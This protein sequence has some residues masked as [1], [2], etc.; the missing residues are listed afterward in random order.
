MVGFEPAESGIVDL[1]DPLA[2]QAMLLTNLLTTEI[3]EVNGKEDLLVPLI[4]D[5]S[6]EVA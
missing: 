4:E 6:G 2:R 3:V 5:F 1:A